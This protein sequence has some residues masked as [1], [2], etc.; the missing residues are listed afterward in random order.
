MGAL[1]PTRL[2]RASPGIFRDQRCRERGEPW[3]QCVGADRV[4]T[5][6]LNLVV[7]TDVN[8]CGDRGSDEP[9]ATLDHGGWQAGTSATINEG[10]GLWLEGVSVLE[11]VD[12]KVNRHFLNT[13]TFDGAELFGELWGVAD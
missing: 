10:F 9:P 13:T 8:T 4:R 1:P 12:D 5:M 11:I 2:R 3:D 7:P 6:I